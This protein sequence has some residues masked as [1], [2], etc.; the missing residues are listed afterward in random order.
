MKMVLEILND[1]PFFNKAR[2]DFKDRI[3]VIVRLGL[4]QFG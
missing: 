2:L 3:Y 1:L 4:I